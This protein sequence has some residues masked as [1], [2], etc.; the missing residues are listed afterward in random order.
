LDDLCFESKKDCFELM[1]RYF[2]EGIADGVTWLGQGFNFSLVEAMEM[3][4]N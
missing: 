4:L 3:D 2:F 1:F